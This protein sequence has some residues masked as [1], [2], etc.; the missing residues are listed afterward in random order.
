MSVYTNCCVYMTLECT[1][2]TIKMYVCTVVA[3][4]PDVILFASRVLLFFCDQSYMVQRTTIEA[5][6]FT[7][8][9]QYP[10]IHYVHSIVTKYIVYV[11]VWVYT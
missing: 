8:Q 10:S 9:A 6:Q 4:Q 3:K 1:T 2:Y 5:V 11:Y 7:I